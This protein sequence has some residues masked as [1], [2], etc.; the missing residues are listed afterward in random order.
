MNLILKAA[1]FCAGLL[2]GVALM[3]VPQ[4]VVEAGSATENFT[5][6]LQRLDEYDANSSSGVKEVT[7][8]GGTRIAY[9][10]GGGKRFTTTAP[11]APFEY[12]GLTNKLVERGVVVKSSSQN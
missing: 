11:P 3:F 2:A 7:Y 5:E 12:V 6:F 1:I 9:I 8:T 4:M 10:T